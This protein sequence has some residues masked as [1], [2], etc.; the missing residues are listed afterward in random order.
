MHILIALNIYMRFLKQV[1]VYSKLM[2][3]SLMWN[4]NNWREKQKGFFAHRLLNKSV[5][6]IKKW[7]NF[8]HM[9]NTQQ[10]EHNIIN[11]C[12]TFKTKCIIRPKVIHKIND[13]KTDNLL[14]NTSN[15]WI[16]LCVLCAF[17]QEQTLMTSMVLHFLKTRCCLK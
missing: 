1:K 3:T 2:I 16:R 11:T 17:F 6:C 9:V 15:I 13:W 5:T 12:L 4:F 10:S 8:T 7:Q 14:G